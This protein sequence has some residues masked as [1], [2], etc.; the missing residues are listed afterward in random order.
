MLAIVFLAA[1]DWEHYGLVNS[2]PLPPPQHIGQSVHVFLGLDGVSRAAFDQAVS[3]GAFQGFATSTLIPMYP[4]TSDASWSRILHTRRFP[5]YEYTYYDETQDTIVDAGLPGILEHIIPPF[6]GT[7]ITQS[8]SHAPAYYK[9]FDVHSSD[10]F[11]A[12]GSYTTTQLSLDKALDQI[13]F[14]LAGRLN[15]QQ[16]FF[17]YL[18]E[19]DVLGHSDSITS[20]VD[21]LKNLSARMQEFRG[22]HPEHPVV[23][24]LFTDHGLD[25]IPKPPDHVIATTPEVAATGVRTVSSF[26]EGRQGPQPWAVVIEHTR[27][28]YAAVHTED[29]QADEVARRISGNPKFDVVVSRSLP[30][31]SDTL[32]AG[33]PRISIWKDGARV[34]YFAFDAGTNTYYLGAG[35]DGGALSVSLPIGFDAFSAFSDAQLFA[36]TEGQAYP[37][38]FFRART[39]LD[40]LSV[41]HPA[42]VMASLKT[43]YVC[44]GYQS[45]LFSAAGT[46]GSHGS[47]ARAGSEGIL[48]TQERTLLPFTR[49]DNLLDMFPDLRAH[50]EERHGPLEPGDPNAALA[51]Q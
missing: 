33:W 43:D 13:F 25:H 51:G 30:A 16:V 14:I 35:F 41:Q 2:V 40:P 27:T 19:T 28:T 50:I 17:A 23:Y 24:T 36:A 9:A 34:A 6:D 21:A 39:A 18:L 46:A 45:F 49:S 37:D 12:I 38:L 32:P 20:V 8:S 11:D 3:E 42:Q 26:F 4:A 47:L 7:P 5:G 1:C 48:A 31:T 44:V 10:Y 15:T 29:A 22:R